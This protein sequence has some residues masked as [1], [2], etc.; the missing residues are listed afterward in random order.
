MRVSSNTIFDHGVS[1]MLARQQEV[2]TTQ[3]HIATGRRVLT[4][5]DDPVAAS[6]MLDVSEAKEANKQFAD[7]AATVKARLGQQ[8]ASLSAITRLIQDVRTLVVQSGSGALTPGDLRSIAEEINGRYDELIGLANATD[9]SGEYLFAGY[10][11]GTRPFAET[12]PGVVAY[13]GDEGRRDVAV[14]TS[15]AIAINDSGAEILHR[16]KNGNG[17]FA[18][19]AAATN[20]GTGVI[21]PG[22]VVDSTALTNHDYSV[23]FTVTGNVTTYDIVDNTTST[24]VVSNAPYVSDGPITVAGMQFAIEGAPANGDSFSVQPSS[25][26]SVFSTMAALRTALRSA[27]HG[28]VANA[29]LTNA[30]NTANSNLTNSLDRILSVTASLGTRLRE[31]EAVTATNEDLDL[32][33]QARLS[34]LGDLDY[35]RAISDLNFQQM[36][37][38]AAQKSFMLVTGLSLFKML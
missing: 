31:T 13:F 26:V 15:R 1:T 6:Q 23:A 7:N 28:D 25:N 3:G 10:R 18:T 8:E 14:S 2:V 17:T 12:S 35:A 16:I 38:E 20:A 34:E 5:S 27:E 24:T 11:T 21:S 4:P 30:L 9:G 37:L 22:S 32:S 33:Y 36:H 19:A 29:S